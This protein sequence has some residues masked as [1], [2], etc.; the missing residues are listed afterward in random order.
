LKSLVEKAIITGWKCGDRVR[1]VAE[2]PNI[3]FYT[4]VEKGACGYL[5]KLERIQDGLEIWSVWM[6]KP[7][8]LKITGFP[9]LVRAT[10][11]QLEKIQ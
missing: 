7:K 1:F 3:P 5:L 4:P 2:L 6:N 9:R 8:D 10:N 11:V